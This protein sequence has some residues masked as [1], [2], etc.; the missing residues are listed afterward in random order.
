MHAATGRERGRH[1]ASPPRD[2]HPHSGVAPQGGVAA[3]FFTSDG[4]ELVRAVT[5][6][7]QRHASHEDG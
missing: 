2:A 5:P 6:G 7:S 1:H 3:S 4:T